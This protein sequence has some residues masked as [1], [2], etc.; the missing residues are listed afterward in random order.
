[1]QLNPTFLNQTS[2]IKIH[3]GCACMPSRSVVSNSVTPGSS[4]HE[5]LEARNWSRLPFP[6]SGD[7]PDPGIELRSPLFQADSLLSEPP[8]K[9]TRVKQVK[10]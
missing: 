4:V 8:A 1:M 3:K 10:N 9:P 7:L 5:T 6:S 2:H